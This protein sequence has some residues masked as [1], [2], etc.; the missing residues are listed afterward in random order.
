MSEPKISLTEIFFITPF[1]LMS[2]AIDLALFMVGLDDF[3]IMDFTRTS[4][5]HIYFV[6]FKNMGPEIWVKNLVINSVKLVPYI[7]SLIP[8][9]FIW[10]VIIFI[11]RGAMNKFQKLMDSKVGGKLIKN[12]AGKVGKTAGKI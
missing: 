8:S 9:T 4:I 1:Y 12:I 2:D 5:G 7:G 11:D 6:V 3:G 10:F